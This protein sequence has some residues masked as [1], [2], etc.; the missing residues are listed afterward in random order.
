M[1]TEI[2]ENKKGQFYIRIKAKNGK[3]LVH[4][5]TYK[6]QHDAVVAVD[7]LRSGFTTEYRGHTQSNIKFIDYVEDEAQ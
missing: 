5:E 1:I 2:I 7:I 3:I 4:S 6:K